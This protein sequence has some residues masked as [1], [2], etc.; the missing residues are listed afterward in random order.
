VSVKDL[1]RKADSNDDGSKTAYVPY[2]FPMILSLAVDQPAGSNKQYDYCLGRADLSLG[3]WVEN[4]DACDGTFDEATQKFN[5]KVSRDGVYTVLFSPRD[6]PAADVDD[7]T[8]FFCKNQEQIIY[9][10][11]I[12]GLVLFVVLYAFW[13]IKR[14][15]KKY[16]K[17]KKRIDTYIKR[18]EQIQKTDTQIHGMT[19]KDKIDGIVFTENPMYDAAMQVQWEAKK[20]AFLK[21]IAET[22]LRKEILTGDINSGEKKTV[23]LKLQLDDLD[24]QITKLKHEVRRSK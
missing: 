7:C 10:V 2:K 16:K 3:K 12:F 22:N 1:S 23:N 18:I 21:S 8:S 6:P 14:Y 24:G 20:T 9:G 11:I 17:Q 4:A 15:V 13:R 5:F 19:V